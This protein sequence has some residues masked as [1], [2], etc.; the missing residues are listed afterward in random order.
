MPATDAP[1][2]PTATH[3]DLMMLFDVAGHALTTEIHAG[4][5]SV[6]ITSREY[7]VMAKASAGT[8]TQREIAALAALDKTTMVVTVDQLEGAGL[9]ERRP[10]PT[11]RRARIVVLTPEGREVLARAEAIVSGI[12]GDVLGSLP[13]TERAGLVA[14]LERLVGA[15]GRLSTSVG[16]AAGIRRRR[17]PTAVS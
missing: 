4:L 6:G 2:D 13:A 3:V 8:A 14:A 11:D 17:S 10:S 15:G 16:G 7:C 1:T 5:A 9:A 12:Y